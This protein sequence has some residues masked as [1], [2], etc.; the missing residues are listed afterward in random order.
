MIFRWLKYISKISSRMSLILPLNADR[1]S[2]G[3]NNNSWKCVSQNLLLL[4][5]R[6]N[7]GLNEIKSVFLADWYMWWKYVCHKCFSSNEFNLLRFVWFVFNLF[8]VFISRG[9]LQSSGTDKDDRS[10]ECWEAVSSL[11][12]E[13]CKYMFNGSAHFS[14]AVS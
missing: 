11:E 1:R 7:R 2:I 3:W 9:C 4:F 8:S 10:G 13:C 5:Q 6:Y 14:V 12:W